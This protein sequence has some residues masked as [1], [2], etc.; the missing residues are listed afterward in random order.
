MKY[1]I[2]SAQLVAISLAG[3]VAW[4]AAGQAGETEHETAAPPEDMPFSHG[5][6]YEL[7]Q[8]NCA[9]CHGAELEGTQQGPP[10]LH[11]YYKPSHHSDASFYRA[12]ESGSPQ[13]HWGFGAMPPVAGA[14]EEQAEAI[15][16]YIRWHQREA[17]LY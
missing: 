3:I 1:P 9:R 4:S 10:L 17:G 15:V 6:G 5:R 13:H 12:I 8:D 7:F 16:E 11:D 14:S 2:R